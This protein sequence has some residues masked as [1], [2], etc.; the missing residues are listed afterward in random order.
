VGLF[1]KRKKTPSG[2]QQ[3][4]QASG[5]PYLPPVDA[6]LPAAQWWAACTSR[7][8]ATFRDHFGSPETFAQPAQDCYGHQEF[9]LA[10]LYYQKAIDLL[11]TLY[12]IGSFERRSP[13]PQD[14]PI[15][16][17]F[18]SSVG[19]SLAMHPGAPID[20]SVREVTHRLRT[21]ATSCDRAGLNS[22]L[23]RNA[24]NELAAAAPNVSL[25]G[26]LG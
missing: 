7:Y 18:L 23:Y 16:D 19:A 24:L 6:A 3:S 2:G 22:G 5:P 10:L 4:T 8:E 21:I 9:G 13:S 26:L 17:G 14:M 12:V 15:T 11:H 25:D 20:D 1:G